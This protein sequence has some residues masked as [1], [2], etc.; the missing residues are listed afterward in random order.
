MSM[1][2]PPDPSAA[3]NLP[4]LP[5]GGPGP[6]GP[7][8]ALNQ[9]PIPGGGGIGDLLAALGG[10]QGGPGPGGP[11]G[12]GDGGPTLPADLQSMDPVQH[13]QVAMQHLMMALAKEPNEADGSGIVKGMGALQAI[14][15]GKQKDQQQRQA[16]ANAPG[17]PPGT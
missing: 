1:M 16:L 17:A 13:I 8:D 10:P 7:M 14:L 9:G 11:P 3:P 4:T 12:P 15:G 2:L 6:P 5:G